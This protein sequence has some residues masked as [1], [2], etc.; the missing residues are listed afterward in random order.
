MVERIS[1]AARKSNAKKATKAKK[2]A[3]KGTKRKKNADEDE[4]EDEDD[5]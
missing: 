3:A 1:A 4:D 2:P 5:D